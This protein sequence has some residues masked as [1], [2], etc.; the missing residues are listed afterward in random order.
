MTDVW[1]LPAIGRWE[2]SCG[3]HPTQKPLGVLA[4]LIQAST[5]SGAWIL[6]PFNGSPTTGIAANLLGRKFLGIEREE[7]FVAISKARR[8]EIEDSRTFATFRKKIPDIVKAEDS[9]T[10]FFVCHESVL[11]EPLPFL[12][13]ETYLYNGDVIMFA[14]G[15][16]SRMKTEQAGRIALG[17]RIGSISQQDVKRVRHVLFHYWN[18]EKAHLYSLLHEPQC[19]QKSK[20][21]SDYLLRQEKDAKFFILLEYNPQEPLNMNDFDFSN[22]QKKGKQRYLPFTT[23]LQSIIK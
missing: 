6:D 13:D 11:I 3:K 18:S 19:V 10:D 2:K 8:E 7:K 17:I 14:V 21:P 4:R 22:V 12:E 9:Q 5:Q 16:N 23:S 15:A 20:I 1:Q